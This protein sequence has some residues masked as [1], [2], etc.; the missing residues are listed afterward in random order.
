M[1]D[2]FI[3]AVIF[4]ITENS[5]LYKEIINKTKNNNNSNNIN[6]IIIVFFCYISGTNHNA[7]RLQLEALFSNPGVSRE[8]IM[9]CN[10]TTPITRLTCY[11]T[12]L[13]Y[14]F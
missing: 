6:V 4:E 10:I 9:V 1:Y 8:Q 14:S 2:I 3:A 13:Q 11:F 12:Y 7:V 5:G